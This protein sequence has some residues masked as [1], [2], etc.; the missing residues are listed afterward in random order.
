MKSKMKAEIS[1]VAT[2][3]DEK[4]RA[5]C[6]ECF[7]EGTKLKVM[8]GDGSAA[9]PFLEEA[10]CLATEEPR[11]PE[12][13]PQVAAYRLAHIRM[14]RACTWEELESIEELFQEA[15]RLG[16]PALGPIPS[17]YRLAV[18]H[19]MQLAAP[20]ARDAESCRRTRNR[21]FRQLCDA[22][23]RRPWD[24]RAEREARI[25]GD[26]HNYL[27][28]VSYFTAE[29]YSHIQGVGSPFG[30]LRLPEEWSIVG[31]HGIAASRHIRFPRALA[32]AELAS[33][34]AMGAADVLFEVDEEACSGHLWSPAASPVRVGVKPLLLLAALCIYSPAATR[35][36]RAMV[37][38]PR[39]AERSLRVADVMAD[40]KERLSGYLG[41]AAE[42]VI[43]PG[44]GRKPPSLS[45]HV[46]IVGMLRRK[47]PQRQSP[48]I[49][50]WGEY[51]SRDG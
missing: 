51:T 25:Q 4:R 12:P 50:D 31:S 3:V 26:L 11:L 36:I 9:V 48:G 14:R 47:D 20:T 13:L 34:A 21:L 43:V 44:R 6:L 42:G 17:V 33:R 18:L 40:L 7:V 28:L 8:A 38:G 23:Q 30:D 19:R 37:M 45:A 15:A 24:E 41:T 10:Y 5:R 1:V 27:E 2:H 29:P 46:R 39:A 35:E 16:T 49:R 32:R 22:I